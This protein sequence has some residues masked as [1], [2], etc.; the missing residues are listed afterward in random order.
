MLSEHS[1]EGLCLKKRIKSIINTL[2]LDI[3]LEISIKEREKYQKLAKDKNLV[4][5]LRPYLLPFQKV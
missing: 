2:K 3:S 1:L 4:S 5:Y